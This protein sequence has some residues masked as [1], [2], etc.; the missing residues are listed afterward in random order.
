MSNFLLVTGKTAAG[1]PQGVAPDMAAE[2]AKRLGVPVAYVKYERPS[3]LGR[4]RR[5]QCLG[6]RADRRRA[7]AGGKDHF[8][9]GLLRDRGDLSGADGLAVSNHR[10]RRPRRR[11][12]HGPARRR[13]RPLARAQHQ[14][15]HAAA[16]GHAPTGRSTS[17]SPRSLEAYAGAAAALLTD[18][19]KLPGG[20]I[21][22]GNFMTVQQAIGTA[23]AEY[24]RR[25]VPQ[26]ICRGG[27]ALRLGGAPDRETSRQRPVGRAP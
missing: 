20:K 8:H 4:C 6:Y 9:A 11:A 22:P 3:H 23:K 18:V 25:R 2:I 10:R 24:R 26:R 12:D 16:V 19:E 5:H 13:L 1:D 17:S 14:A 21:L 15:R 7:A 27:Q